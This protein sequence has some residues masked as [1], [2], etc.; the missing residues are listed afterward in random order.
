MKLRQ[1]GTAFLMIKPATLVAGRN[2]EPQNIEYRISKD[3]NASL[4]LFLNRQNTFI[5]R[6]MFDV[7]QFLF[8]LDWPLFRPAAGLNTDT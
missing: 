2:S 1:N 6:S 8:R 7:H 3:G 4:N 5:R